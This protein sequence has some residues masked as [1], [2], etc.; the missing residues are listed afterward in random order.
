MESNAGNSLSGSSN[1]RKDE[2]RLVAIVWP[3]GHYP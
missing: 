1:P 3:P 2:R